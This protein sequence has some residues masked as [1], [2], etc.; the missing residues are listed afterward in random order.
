MDVDPLTLPDKA[1]HL[2]HSRTTNPSLEIAKSREED[3]QDHDSGAQGEDEAEGF[4]EG[5]HG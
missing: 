1:L 2:Q 3:G 4:V 5:A